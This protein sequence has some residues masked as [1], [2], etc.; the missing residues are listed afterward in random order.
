MR[1]NRYELWRL[2]NIGADVFYKLVF[3]NRAQPQSQARFAV[4][5]E[6]GIPVWDVDQRDTLLLPP[7]KR[8]DVLVAA[9]DA[10]TYDL[11]SL[12]TRS[13]TSRTL[14]RRRLRPPWTP[15]RC[16]WRS[17]TARGSPS[18]RRSRRRA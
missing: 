6:D 13:A 17:S 5:A 2:A 9:P 8:F 14:P 18:T 16:R 10:G 3:R 12:R 15:S 4:I 7:G 1:E 11:V